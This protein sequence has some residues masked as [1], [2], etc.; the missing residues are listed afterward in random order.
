[1]LGF[2]CVCVHC[3]G[4]ACVLTVGLEDLLS[5]GLSSGSRAIQSVK[6]VSNGAYLSVGCAVG[7]Q[8][9]QSHYNTAVPSV[10]GEYLLTEVQ[11]SRQLFFV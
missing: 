10:I 6:A 4:V 5:L 9:H 7:S 2:L 3:S 1:M 11:L 8:S